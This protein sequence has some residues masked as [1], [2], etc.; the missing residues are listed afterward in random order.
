MVINAV[1]EPH[2][3]TATLSHTIPVG[4]GIVYT[5]DSLWVPAAAIQIIANGTQ[6]ID[7]MLYT[8]K[9]N[10]VSKPSFVP[11][12][13]VLYSLQVSTARLGTLTTQSLS[14]LDT[15]K[16]AVR[17]FVKL[18]TSPWGNVGGFGEIYF[19]LT[20]NPNIKYYEVTSSGAYPDC[21]T[22][23]G[24]KS[25]QGNI[26]NIIFARNY[27]ASVHNF[28]SECFEYDTLNLKA[29]MELACYSDSLG[30]GTFPLP[31]ANWV[32]LVV[33]G[34]SYEYY[35]YVKDF[36]ASGGYEDRD[37]FFQGLIE[38]ATPYSNVTGG[39]GVFYART[40]S[41]KFIKVPN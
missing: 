21:N 16:F 12:K 10:Y 18:P 33:S 17:N 7:T 13:N 32:K 2:Q 9:G 31:D 22:S 27:N 3:I 30:G 34:C 6:I 40:R 8:T 25:L 37:D 4:D 19:T 39:Y 1:L 11:Q 5:I 26:C 24:L 20:N 28:S 36:E 38:P 23:T 15:P 29:S 41:T 35:K 14:V